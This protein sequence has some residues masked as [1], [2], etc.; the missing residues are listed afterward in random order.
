MILVCRIFV[1]KLI[2]QEGVVVSFNNNYVSWLN[3]I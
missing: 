1:K 3:I 2:V